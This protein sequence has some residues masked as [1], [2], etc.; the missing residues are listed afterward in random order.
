MNN[1]TTT[2]K[3]AI[4]NA[5]ANITIQLTIWGG[6]FMLVN[7]NINCIANMVVF[8]AQVFRKRACFIYLF[9]ESV[10]NFFFFNGILVTRV[11]QS[12]FQIPIMNRYDIAC[13][14]RE[15]ISEY[16]Y[17]ASNT[18]F[19]LATLDRLLSTQRSISKY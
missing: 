15:F 3:N 12:G 1:T 13:K 9:W 8:R 19:L 18:F 16:L 10:A 6:L 11:L 7:G 14:I 5:L 4:E 17:Q 2:N